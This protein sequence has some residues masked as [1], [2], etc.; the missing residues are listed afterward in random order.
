LTLTLT[1]TSGVHVQRGGAVGNK[2]RI[3]HTRSL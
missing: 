1:L 3:L 2:M